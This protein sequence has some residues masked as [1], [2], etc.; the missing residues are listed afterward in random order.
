MVGLHWLRCRCGQPLG[1]VGTRPL[2]E[3]NGRH[4]DPR[5]RDA[6]PQSLGA[7]PPVTH[8]GRLIFLW[9]SGQWGFVSLKCFPFWQMD[10]CFKR[11]MHSGI[12]EKPLSRQ[13]GVLGEASGSRGAP[14]PSHHR[15]S[16][17]DNQI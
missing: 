1:L 15:P 8:T 5:P 11:Q 3:S 17:D 4:V 14:P 2:S 9:D 16:K 12:N 10:Q 13:S 7:P 6:K